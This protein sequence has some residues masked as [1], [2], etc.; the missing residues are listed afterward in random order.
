PGI[1][2]AD[3]WLQLAS[4]P[5]PPEDEDTT[6]DDEEGV[7]RTS[8][9]TAPQARGESANYPIRR[10]M[11]LVENIADKQTAISEVDWTSWL[12]RLE[13]TLNQMSDCGVLNEFRKLALNPLA[14]LLEPSFRPSFAE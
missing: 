8:N 11:E 4:F 14:P 1:E 2:I 10:M 7:R 3:A 9:N 12:C 13:Q 5:M 6:E